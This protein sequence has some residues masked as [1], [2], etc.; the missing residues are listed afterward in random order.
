MTFGILR[1]TG[2]LRTGELPHHILHF[3][4]RDALGGAPNE[5]KKRGPAERA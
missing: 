2:I 4:D 3:A 5:I 1:T